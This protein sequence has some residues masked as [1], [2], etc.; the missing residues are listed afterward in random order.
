MKMTNATQQSA[1]KVGEKRYS[2]LGYCFCCMIAQ[3]AQFQ[4]DFWIVCWIRC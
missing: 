1:L 3:L 2:L 4:F